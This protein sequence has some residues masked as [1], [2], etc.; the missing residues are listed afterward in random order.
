MD[1]NVFLNT[2][3]LWFLN[4][5]HTFSYHI[6]EE[7]QE[8][9]TVLKPVYYR[10]FFLTMLSKTLTCL[11]IRCFKNL[12]PAVTIDCC[13]QTDPP[14]EMESPVVSAVDEKNSAIDNVPTVQLITPSPIVVGRRSPKVLFMSGI[15]IL[16]LLA[17]FTFFG[18]VEY[19]DRVQ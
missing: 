5:N 8:Y 16:A 11:L 9:V 15:T 19:G 1:N 3:F 18:G 17:I 7:F 6:S 13:T 10:S 12:F 2:L 4:F 14:I